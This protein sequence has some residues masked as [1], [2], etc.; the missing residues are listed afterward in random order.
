MEIEFSQDAKNKLA[1][2]GYDE[3]FGAR[4]LQSVFNRLVIRPL[5]KFILKGEEGTGAVSVTLKDDQINL[6]QV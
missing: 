4:P 1:E 6:I 2:L 5:S 3:K